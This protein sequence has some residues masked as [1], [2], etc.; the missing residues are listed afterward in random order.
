MKN[1]I[2]QIKNTFKF[3]KHER[4]LIF[5]ALFVFVFFITF[6][7]ISSTIS[8][9]EQATKLGLSSLRDA[10]AIYYGSHEG[11]YPSDDIAQILI[12]EG[13]IEKIPYSFINGKSN[14]I[15]VSD[16]QKFKDKGGWIYITPAFEI[17]DKPAGTIWVNSSK[18]D[19]K[20]NLWNQI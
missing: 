6:R 19:S 4:I 16:F 2:S 5:I 18:K 10:I 3:N 15:I 7:I 11:K 20:G 1:I 13:Y 12:D 17:A 9:N 14:K 8:V